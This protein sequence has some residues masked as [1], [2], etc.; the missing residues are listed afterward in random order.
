MPL[1]GGKIV[2]CHKMLVNVLIQVNCHTNHEIPESNAMSILY[3]GISKKTS[4]CSFSQQREQ[5]KPEDI[6]D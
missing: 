6:L 5:Q 2:A 3:L 1:M 4:S